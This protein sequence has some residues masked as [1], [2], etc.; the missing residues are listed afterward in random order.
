MLNLLLTNVTSVLTLLDYNFIRDQIELRLEL[1]SILRAYALLL[2]FFLRMFCSVRFY[3][4]VTKDIG[5]FLHQSMRD[6]PPFA[7][8]VK[9]INCNK[10]NK[11]R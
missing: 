6:H 1:N 9:E 4:P 8:N 7:A 3:I 11:M 10:T 2:I 5:I